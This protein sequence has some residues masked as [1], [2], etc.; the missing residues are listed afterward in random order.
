MG[1]S[2]PGNLE[3]FLE[4]TSL[5]K[6]KDLEDFEINLDASILPEDE[7]IQIKERKDVF[8]EM[9]KEARKKAKIAKKMALDAYLEANKIKKAYELDSESESE[10]EWIE[11]MA[12][13]IE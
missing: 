12:S 5:G 4:D 3:E 1:E 8:Y 13:S 2:G 10:D 6:E 9:Y 11:E 7:M